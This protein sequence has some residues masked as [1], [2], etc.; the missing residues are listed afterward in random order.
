M[1]FSRII[2]LLNKVVGIELSLANLYFFLRAYPHFQYFQ[3]FKVKK[4]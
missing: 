4:P 3:S 2:E 1:I